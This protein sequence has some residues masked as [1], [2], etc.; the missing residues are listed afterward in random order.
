MIRQDK[1]KILAPFILFLS[2]LLD[3]H[4]S[5]VIASF[6]DNRYL[7]SVHLT[8]VFLLVISKLVNEQFL[9]ITMIVIGMIIDIY[10]TGM[11]G[12]YAAVMPLIV[13]LMYKFGK[14][15]HQNIF[16]MF[17]G[18][19]IFVTIWNVALLL[20]QL[21]F[22]LVSVN[23][24]YFITQNLWP[25][26]IANIVVFIIVIIPIEAILNNPDEDANF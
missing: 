22:R 8:L 21:V 23:L 4:I 17:F 20:L 14:I 24:L 2:L 16:T 13:W 6:F 9:I 18:M 26:L 10:Y 25:S 1:V 11:I 12:I 5:S 3:A 19:I 7:V 15:I